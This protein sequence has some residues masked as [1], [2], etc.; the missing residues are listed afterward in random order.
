MST[1][2]C[3]NHLWTNVVPSAYETWPPE[4][5]LTCKYCKEKQYMAKSDFKKLPIQES[6]TSEELEKIKYTSEDDVDME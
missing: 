2:K 4:Y 5:V 3:L 6:Y 1:E